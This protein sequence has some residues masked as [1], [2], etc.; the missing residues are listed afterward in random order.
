MTKPFEFAPTIYDIICTLEGIILIISLEIYYYS[1]RYLCLCL[2]KALQ[3][4]LDGRA[5]L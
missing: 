5:D 2:K 4:A 3:L 1:S